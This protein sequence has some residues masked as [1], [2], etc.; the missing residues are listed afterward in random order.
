MSKTKNAN[1]ITVPRREGMAQKMFDAAGKK[2]PN[3]LQNLKGML[4]FKS[5][6]HGAMNMC[7]CTCVCIYVC[8][9]IYNTYIHIYI[10]IYM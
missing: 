9:H 4:G 6:T 1:P 7:I 10:Y 2:R 5:K 3:R 8:L